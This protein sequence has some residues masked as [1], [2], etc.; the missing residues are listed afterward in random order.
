MYTFAISVLQ[1]NAV[2]S[3]TWCTFQFFCS[4]IKSS[5]RAMMRPKTGRIHL[6]VPHC[7]CFHKPNVLPSSVL[8]SFQHLFRLQYPIVQNKALVFWIV[9][10]SLP[11]MAW[12]RFHYHFTDGI[13]FC[14]LSQAG[15]TYFLGVLWFLFR[16][17]SVDDLGDTAEIAWWVIEISYDSS[18][19]CC[20]LCSALALD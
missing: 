10:P 9:E 2:L 7:L 20:E 17:L 14:S 12:I 16:Y 18:W 15:H 5:K 6:W 4:A 1:R 13:S 11:F 8:R 19:L 3:S